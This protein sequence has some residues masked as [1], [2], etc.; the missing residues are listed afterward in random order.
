[1]SYKL[2]DEL[3]LQHMMASF[4]REFNKDN[5]KVLPL[6]LINLLTKIQ[7]KHC[8]AAG[9]TTRAFP[10]VPQIYQALDNETN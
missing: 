3:S 2:L 1:M 10:G 9:L 6:L 4:N 8:H 5:Y 7:N